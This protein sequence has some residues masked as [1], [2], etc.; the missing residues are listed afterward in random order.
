MNDVAP[1]SG[2]ARRHGGLRLLA[3][4]RSQ[5]VKNALASAVSGM[6]GV[7]MDVR[8]GELKEI[9]AQPVHVQ[10]P[11]I[12]VLDVDANDQQ[13][14]WLLSRIVHERAGIGPVL[15]TASQVT[16]EGVRRLVRQGI[17]DFIPQPATQRDVLDAFEVASRK[18]RQIRTSGRKFG[19]VITFLKAS[20][21]MGTTTL[22]MH[23]AYNL[24]R[25]GRKQRATVCVIDLDLHFG[26]AALYF[27]LESKPEI[28]EIV[29]SPERLDGA[30]LRTAS[31]VHASGLHVLT[32]PSTAMP[33]EALTGET[34]EKLLQAAREE[35]EYVVVDLPPALTSWLD[36]VLSLSDQIF[37][38]TQLSV[39]AVRQSRRLLELLSDEGLYNLPL[40]VVLNRYRRRWRDRVRLRQCEKALGRR[41]DYRIGSDYDLVVD[42]L[43]QG[44]PIYQIR[45]W[46]R[47]GRQIRALTQSSLKTLA[48]HEPAAPALAIAPASGS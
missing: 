18:L 11:D 24:L 41:F 26:A 39:P 13:E 6:D 27:D 23:Y 20:G 30:F 7:E 5:E 38:V 25:P 44:K 40:A 2:F 36:T 22:A 4:V 19:R 8:M 29:R 45:R 31:V 14:M 34:V 21:G 33:L 17:D 35:Y 32:A 9:G 10:R 3:I 48:E 47:V 28:L 37:L 15:A 12:V 1:G 46:S 43:N 42:A 16:A